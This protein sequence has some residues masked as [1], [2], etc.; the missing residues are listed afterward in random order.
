MTPMALAL[1]MGGGA[2][3]DRAERGAAA[4]VAVSS[5]SSSGAPPFPDPTIADGE[6]VCRA[7]G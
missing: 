6:R 7:T 3:N 4:A 2:L 1:L 5:R